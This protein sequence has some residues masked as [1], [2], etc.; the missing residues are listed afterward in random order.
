MDTAPAPSTLKL[1]KFLADQGVAAR[2]VV[3][4]YIQEGRVKVNGEVAHLGQR[5]DPAKDSVE[6]DGKTFRPTEAAPE[7]TRIFALYKPV[8]VISTS[9]DPLGRETLLQ[10]AE[11]NWPA[12]VPRPERLLFA[13][14]LDEVSEGLVIAS[15]N[16]EFIQQIT[17]PSFQIPKTYLVAIDRNPSS[18]ALD[19]LERGVRIDGQYLQPTSIQ[20]V[21][22]PHYH[23]RSALLT[24]SPEL[25]QFD[26]SPWLELTI[27]FGQHH[28]VKRLLDRVGYTIRQL[29]RI[30]VR[31]FSISD[32]KGQL[33]RELP[34]KV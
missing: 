25:R 32:L 23:L 21:I 26:D 33:V 27:T 16:G 24:L 3:E 14:R 20:P 6:F 18:A 7:K 11:A 10:F 8:G 15:N 2:R 5:V 9:A 4:G 22:F 19:H 31:P 28:I 17:H 30:G 29:V 12:E 13:G 1:Q 34:Y